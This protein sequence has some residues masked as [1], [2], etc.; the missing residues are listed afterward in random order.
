MSPL[1]HFSLLPTSKMS[2]FSRITKWKKKREDRNVSAPLAR[3]I[4][5]SL[6]L[7][8]PRSAMIS[9]D[10]SSRPS[11]RTSS[12]SSARR[13]LLHISSCSQLVCP[14]SKGFSH[15]VNVILRVIL[16]LLLT[17]FILILFSK[18]GFAP[19]VVASLPLCMSLS[20]V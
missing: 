10:C 3:K 9:A 1:L 2:R 8:P 20:N 19:V 18:K 6:Y 16:K 12:L 11:L 15:R 7:L 5:L 14:T 4:L 17:F 13:K